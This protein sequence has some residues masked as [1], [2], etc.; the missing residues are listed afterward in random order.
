VNFNKICENLQN[1]YEF[2]QNFVKI[3]QNLHGFSAHNFFCEFYMIISLSVHFKELIILSFGKNF[4]LIGKFG[5]PIIFLGFWVE[6]ENS[7]GLLLYE[8]LAALHF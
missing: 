1:L 6:P 5:V 7:F 4:V 2:S 3:H 8:F